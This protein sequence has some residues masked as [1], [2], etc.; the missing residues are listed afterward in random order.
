MSTI[1]YLT[2]IYT[3]HIPQNFVSQTKDLIREFLW[4]GKTWRIAQNTL[5]LKKEHG[6]IELQDIDNYISCKKIKWILRIHCN[7]DC[8]W[9]SY[10][11]YCFSL[12]DETFG[13]QNFLLQSSSN[14][15]LNI[16][17]PSFYQ[18]CLDSWYS[19]KKKEKSYCIE[20]V[21]NQNLFG[22][23]HISKKQQ[24]LFF[25]NWTKSNLSKIRDIWNSETKSWKTG[26]EIH[27]QL[28]NKRNWIAEYNK[29]KSCIP[30]EWKL[31]LKD[32]DVHQDDTLLQ[33][34]RN[35][36]LSENGLSLDNNVILLKKVK[37][38]DIYF[39]C[40]YPITKP[41]CISAWIKI[42]NKNIEVKTLQFK[43]H[44]IFNKKAID[45]HWKSLHRAIYT[46]NRLSKMKR[47]NG[48]CK[49]CLTHT[50]TLCHLLSECK[51][52]YS[53]WRNVEKLLNHLTGYSLD[54]NKYNIIFGVKEDKTYDTMYNFIVYNTK[55]CLWKNRNNV[56]YG[57]ENIKNA[58]TV[59]NDIVSFC[60][61]EAK[62]I[63]NSN[64]NH[65][66]DENLKLFLNNIVNFQSL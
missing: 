38:K 7:N 24:S 43:N 6:G 53:V 12:A 9:N 61:S 56:R 27:T 19:V 25:T 2:D 41:S 55:W 20:D 62:V 21:L 16:E 26:P 13:I 51:I 30:K 4:S 22:N 37:Q 47:S 44:C 49:L 65:K 33:N 32:E 1:S 64:Y 48:L 5:A 3:N 50:E 34:S 10:G 31:L 39:A 46:E 28:K 66:L 45:F 35:I 58:D 11:K 57:K 18:T 54:L 42:F 14:K 60:K 8:K 36:K 23:C 15:G 40:L 63:T 17:L 52:A 59:F 29:I